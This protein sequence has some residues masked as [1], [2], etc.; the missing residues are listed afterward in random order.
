MLALLLGM[1][2]FGWGQQ[3]RKVIV[4]EDGAGPA[5]T[6]QQAILVMLQSPRVDVLGITIVTGDQWRDEEVAHTLRTLELTRRT[7]IPVVPGAVFPLIRTQQEALQW[8]SGWELGGH[9]QP[10]DLLSCPPCRRGN[11]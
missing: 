5:G 6:A 3:A 10:T 11:R 4:D 7:A 1:I 8:E 2:P 9:N